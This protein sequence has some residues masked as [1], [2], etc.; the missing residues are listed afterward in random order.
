MGEHGRRHVRMAHEV[1]RRVDKLVAAVAADV[2]EGF[3]AVGDDALAVRGGNQALL[4]GEA[5]FP[6]G[7]RLVISH[8]VHPQ[9]L[10]LLSASRR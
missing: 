1:V 8:G 4:G 2:D 9:G 6:L 10:Q 3:V 5:T 7:D